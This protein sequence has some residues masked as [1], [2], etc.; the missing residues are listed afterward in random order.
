MPLYLACRWRQRLK[1]LIL[2]VPYSS[3][4]LAF[5]THVSPTAAYTAWGSL[6]CCP[7]FYGSFGSVPLG[8]VSKFGMLG[9]VRTRGKFNGF[10]FS[11][12]VCGASGSSRFV[13][14]LT[15]FSFWWCSKKG[16]STPS[17]SLR[18]SWVVPLETTSN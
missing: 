15:F 5:R 9:L 6:F 2:G 11:L 8:A 14:E 3:S 4:A 18:F 13:T 10:N 7:F 16:N 1:T 12:F 17:D